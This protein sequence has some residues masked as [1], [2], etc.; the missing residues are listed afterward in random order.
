MQT[1]SVN[2]KIITNNNLSLKGRKLR[3]S[4]RQFSVISILS[5]MYT[6]YVE[7][8]CERISRSET[9]SSGLWRIQW[10]RRTDGWLEFY[11][12]L[13]T[14]IVM[15]EIECTVAVDR[16]VTKVWSLDWV[17]WTIYSTDC[18]QLYDTCMLQYRFSSA[19]IPLLQRSVAKCLV[20][21]TSQ[22]ARRELGRVTD[23]HA[24]M[25][26]DPAAHDN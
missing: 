12:A 8:C 14:H 25:C 2:Y 9:L 4:L 15:S 24:V 7:S 5:P 10:H 22:V 1:A 13:N 21:K 6:V 3:Y 16:L 18:I 17:D 19:C 26:A 11:D 23:R 20:I